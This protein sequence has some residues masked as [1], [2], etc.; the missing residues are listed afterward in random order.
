MKT[1]PDGLPVDENLNRLCAMGEMDAVCQSADYGEWIEAIFKDTDVKIERHSRFGVLQT[2][3]L[4]TAFLLSPQ[5]KADDDN[6]T[7]NFHVY[8]ML[9]TNA[10]KLNLPQSS[11]RFAVPQIDSKP[12]D[13]GGEPKTK[14]ADEIADEAEVETLFNGFVKTWKDDTAGSSLIMRRYAHPSYQAILVLGG[15]EPHVVELILRE[16]QKS[17]DMWF[18]ALR[19]LT[20]EDPAKDAKN[21]EDTTKAWLKWW[22]DKQLI[23]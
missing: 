19:R 16:L 15:K 2:S 3:A 6:P 5:L 10:E 7:E 23:A 13:V 1:L 21:F 11:A 22:R 18:E 8:Y 9:V 14:S 20:N 17:P 4:V 12:I